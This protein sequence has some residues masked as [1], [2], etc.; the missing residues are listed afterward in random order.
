MKILIQSNQ[1][2]LESNRLMSH[3]SDIFSSHAE[4][5][6]SLSDIRESKSYSYRKDEIKLIN[7]LVIQRMKSLLD[8]IKYD[9][10]NRTHS[11][12]ILG[13]EIKL[14]LVFDEDDELLLLNDFYNIIQ[15]S[16]LFSCSLDIRA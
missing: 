3:L 11:F 9:N 8:I 13:E 2:M 12:C 1:M 7:D 16:I 14:S 5:S 6:K 15:N 10:K 4:L